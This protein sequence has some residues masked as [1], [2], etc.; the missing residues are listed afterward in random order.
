MNLIYIYVYNTHIKNIG[1]TNYLKNIKKM[2]V[3]LL[4]LE[5][6]FLFILFWYNV[7]VIKLYF[8]IFIVLSFLFTVIKIFI[9]FLKYLINFMS[10]W[11]SYGCIATIFVSPYSFTPMCPSRDHHGTRPGGCYKMFVT[12]RDSYCSAV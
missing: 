5:T 1:L 9:K 4:T 12:K 8:N 2:F 3:K 7:Q 10:N 6:F 11:L